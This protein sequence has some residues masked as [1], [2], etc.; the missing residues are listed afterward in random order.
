MVWEKDIFLSMHS[1]YKLWPVQE[2]ERQS[3][4]LSYE[5]HRKKNEAIHLKL[6]LQAVPALC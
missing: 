2:V 1:L 3:Q 4:K 6:L 5:M